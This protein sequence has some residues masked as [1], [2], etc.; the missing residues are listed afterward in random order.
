[1]K[2]EVGKTYVTK[3]GEKILIVY[4]S[5]QNSLPYLG[6]WIGK[7]AECAVWYSDVGTNYSI[8]DTLIDE[9]HD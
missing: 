3:N 7:G 5:E 8:W 4:K 6:V 2:P 1:M 9:C